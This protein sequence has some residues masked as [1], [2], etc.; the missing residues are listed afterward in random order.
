MGE[1]AIE[2]EAGCLTLTG[3]GALTFC[4]FGDY[5]AEQIPVT[6]R[7]DERSFEGSFG[8]GCVAA[9]IHCVLDALE[10]GREPENLD[11][12]Y[13]HVMKATDSAYMSARTGRRISLSGRR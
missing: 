10:E 3:D 7:I 13:M 4:A 12:D 11:K 1:M 2:G 6:R 9:P 5:G 8:G